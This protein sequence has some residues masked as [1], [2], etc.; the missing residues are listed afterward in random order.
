MLIS[1]I[2]CTCSILCGGDPVYRGKIPRTEPVISF[3]INWLN[4][5]PAKFPL[6]TCYVKRRRLTMTSGPNNH[7]PASSSPVVSRPTIQIRLLQPLLLCSPAMA[8]PCRTAT[9]RAMRP[10]TGYALNGKSTRSSS[11]GCVRL[12]I[13]GENSKVASSVSK[14]LEVRSSCAC[15][16]L[17]SGVPDYQWRQCIS[18]VSLVSSASTSALRLV[19]SIPHLIFVCSVSHLFCALSVPCLICSASHLF[20]VSSVPRLICSAS[21]PFRVSSFPR[22]ISSVSHLFLVLS[23]SYLIC[24]S[25]CLFRVSSVPRLKFNC[26]PNPQAFQTVSQL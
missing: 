19:S 17:R 8:H 22:L 10:K 25:Y 24:S 7:H 16:Q 13:V 5:T 11:D 15:L 14:L 4:L 9:D 3:L 6:T 23:I 2:P 18:A 21:Y 12:A 20:R 26:F 1:F